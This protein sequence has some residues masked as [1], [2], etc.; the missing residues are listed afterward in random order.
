M[1]SYYYDIWTILKSLA[2]I[3][4]PFEDTVLARG[5]PGPSRKLHGHT[6]SIFKWRKRYVSSHIRI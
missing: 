6:I 3:L 4:L 1:Y 5:S 2:K